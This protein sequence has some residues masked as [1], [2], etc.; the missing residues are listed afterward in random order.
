VHTSQEPIFGPFA[1]NTIGGVE[2]GSR[3]TISGNSSNGVEAPPQS[4]PGPPV[5]VLGNYIGLDITAS[6]DLGYNHSGVDINI[7]PSSVV[8]G[9]SISGNGMWGTIFNDPGTG[10]VEIAGN[11]V[12]TDGS[13]T[14]KIENVNGGVAIVAGRD[15]RVVGNLIS[16]NKTRGLLGFALSSTGSGASISAFIEDNLIG[17]DVTGSRPLGNELNGVVIHGA[18]RAVVHNNTISGNG[19]FGVLIGSTADA[20]ADGGKDHQLFSLGAP[21]VLR[22][23][24]ERDGLVSLYGTEKPANRKPHILNPDRS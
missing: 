21:Q 11:F 23:F 19:A 17:T 12:G 24:V 22:R 1:G 8:R 2:A 15:S 3:N 20:G 10:R 16:G 18:F 14:K 6:A 9:N 4:Q 5:F 7:H 13:G